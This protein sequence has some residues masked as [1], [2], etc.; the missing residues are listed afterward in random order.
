MSFSLL[1]YVWLDTNKEF[2]SNALIVRN[3]DITSINEVKPRAIDFIV[4][5]DGKKGTQS[6]ILHPI[7]LYNN[8]FKPGKNSYLVLCNAQFSN[9]DFDRKIYEMPFVLSAKQQF[10]LLNSD[11]K[12][13]NDKNITN[14]DDYKKSFHQVIYKSGRKNSDFLKYSDNLEKSLLIAGIR[15]LEI[16]TTVLSQI[17]LTICENDMTLCDDLIMTRYISQTL[18]NGLGLNAIFDNKIENDVVLN[19]T[20]CIFDFYTKE[21]MEEKKGYKVIQQMVL[22][23]KSHHSEYNHKCLV[24]GQ[25]KSEFK[26]SIGHFTGS[27]RIPVQTFT[28]KRGSISDLRGLSN[29][30]PYR[31]VNNILKSLG[32]KSKEF[33]TMEKGLEET[34]NILSDMENL[35]MFMAPYL[36]DIKFKLKEKASKIFSGIP[37]EKREKLQNDLNNI[38]EKYDKKIIDLLKE[39]K[40]G[41]MYDLVNKLLKEMDDLIPTTDINLSDN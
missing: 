22:L 21:M 35:S 5:K 16:N 34:T 1:T 13:I 41:P 23:L 29:C 38:R 20:K 15:V 39:R 6:A 11:N 33:Y 24:K 12:L 7:K 18:A 4:E 8:C 3:N 2:C 17:E 31:V 28:N 14:K 40:T 32:I 36:D 26:M 9:E 19:K 27:I 10:Y 25:D 30:N 37:E